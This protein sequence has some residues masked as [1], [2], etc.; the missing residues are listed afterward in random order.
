MLITKNNGDDAF[1]QRIDEMSRV[2][3]WAT[4]RCGSLMISKI[5]LTHIPGGV[6]DSSG[7]NIIHANGPGLTLEKNIVAGEGILPV[8][9]SSALTTPMT[10][11]ALQRALFD[12]TPNN[13]SSALDEIT[14]GYDPGFVAKNLNLITRNMDNVSGPKL[15]RAFCDPKIWIDGLVNME[16]RDAKG[17]FTGRYVLLNGS[18]FEAKYF[19]YTDLPYGAYSLFT[20]SK[21]VIYIPPNCNGCFTTNANIAVGNPGMGWV[22]TADGV[23]RVDWEILKRFGKGCRLVW[24]VFRDN[25]LLS[26]NNFAEVFNIATEAKHEKINMKI[27]RAEATVEARYG[28]WEAQESLLDDHEV[29][30][31][32]RKYG[33]KIDPVWDDLPGEINFEGAW[34]PLRP[35]FWNGNHVA[36]FFGKKSFDFLQKYIEPT[37]MA[38]SKAL[39]VFDDKDKPMAKRFSAAG[40]RNVRFATS[41]VFNDKEAFLEKVPAIAD[42][43]FIVVSDE[44]KW[45]L[46]TALE[47]CDLAELPVGIF[48]QSEDEPQQE[49]ASETVYCVMRSQSAEDVFSIKN[50]ENNSIVNY[51]FSPSGVEETPGTEEDMRKG[52]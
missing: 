21:S 8:G 41:C 48:S 23:E 14:G 50:M 4:N 51:K 18:V 32:A 9:K 45:D 20:P 31:F 19:K 29:K 15:C 34:V 2:T 27:I 44:M 7:M 37:S 49:T 12:I 42:I 22:G 36:V 5:G 30:K 35:P 39:V 38:S 10:S 11:T 13:I 46:Q 52:E 17:N 43:V 33:L 16:C 25:L 1:R 28:M 3:V 47:L 6:V 24:P 26:K 40:G